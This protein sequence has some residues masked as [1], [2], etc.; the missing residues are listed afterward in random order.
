MEGP[1]ILVAEFL[2]ATA[3]SYYSVWGVTWRRAGKC[4]V[5]WISLAAFSL[6]ANFK[7]EWQALGN[8][9]G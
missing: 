7:W 8:R 2:Q 5:L 4:S 1:V 6:H 3:K 9:D